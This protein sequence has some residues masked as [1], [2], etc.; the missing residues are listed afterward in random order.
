MRS[1]IQRELDKA[2]EYIL[3]ALFGDINN[4]RISNKIKLFLVAKNI[5]F[6]DYIN[7]K[8]DVFEEFSKEFMNE[9]GY[10]I[11]DKLTQAITLKYPY[12]Q[13][14]QIPNIKPIDLFKSLNQLVGI[15]TIGQIIQTL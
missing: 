4:P 1:Q 2:E 9:D 15:E 11:G 12:L 3:T 8:I 10:Y 5:N 13:G 7:S 14:I 6:D